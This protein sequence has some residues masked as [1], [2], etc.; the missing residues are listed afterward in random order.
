VNAENAGRPAEG[1]VALWK[2]VSL[3]EARG[4]KAVLEALK[5]ASAAGKA[6]DSE[7]FARALALQQLL[8]DEAAVEEA[9]VFA[10]ARIEASHTELKHSR[11]WSVVAS[12]ARAAGDL[13]RAIEMCIEA[14]GPKLE[15]P[16]W[17]AGL[18]SIYLSN[19]FLTST[20]TELEQ[21]LLRL[22]RPR[23]G[24]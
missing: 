20:K 7:A 14:L 3:A 13:V 2:G 10:L 17:H 23:D 12:Q 22:R 9:L 18:R 21:E 19:G 4:S 6:V 16:V 15:K 11:E 5:E 8:F 24:L 1:L